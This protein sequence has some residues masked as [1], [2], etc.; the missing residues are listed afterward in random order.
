[1][2][3]AAVQVLLPLDDRRAVHITTVLKKGVGEAVRG[4]VLGSEVLHDYVIAEVSE[5]GMRLVQRPGS[6][7]Q[8][9]EG[10]EP[11]IDLVL[12]APRPSRVKQLLPHIAQ[13]GVRTLVFLRAEKVERGYLE[14]G[15]LH[16]DKEDR[17]APPPPSAVT[18]CP[19]PPPHPPHSQ[20]KPP[21]WTRWVHLD[22]PGHRHGQQPRL[23]D[24]RP[25]E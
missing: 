2:P 13:L 11:I 17:H 15:V 7:A 24:G 6:G 23:R 14:T 21:Q 5:R 1:M 8:A 10:R 16:P 25:P 4:A 20:G 18:C 9:V 19:P 22:A 3:P 12:A